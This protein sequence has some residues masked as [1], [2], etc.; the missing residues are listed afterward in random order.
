MRA[1]HR[2][3]AAP[4][5]AALAAAAAACASMG[6]PPGGPEDRKAP[7]LV[8]TAP[9]SAAVNARPDRVVFEF[10]E[11]IAERP[12]GGAGG[13]A[14]LDAAFLISPRDGEP[15]V[16]WRRERLSVRPRRGWRPNTVYTVTLLPGV[17]DLRGNARKE[18]ARV[19]F[20]TGATIPETRI[21]GVAFDW[22]AGKV[23]TRA[24]V[25][26]ISRPDST[27]YVTLSDSAGRFAFAHVPPGRYTIR[28][29]GDQ[30]NNRVLD[31]RELWDSAA[32][33]LRDTASAELYAFVHDTTGPRLQEVAVADSVTLRA[34]LDKPL[35]PTQTLT[36]ALF[37]LRAADSSVVPIVAALAPADF[38]AQQG[39]AARSRAD[40]LARADSARAAA[41]TIHKGPRLP[42]PARDSAGAA[43]DSLARD[44]PRLARP[45]PVSEV[46]LRLGRALAPA[47]AYRLR[48]VGLRNLLGIPGTSDRIITTPRPKPP[49][50]S[51]RA[52][53]A[54]VPRPVARV[55]TARA[56]PRAPAR[57]RPLG[58]LLGTI[59]VLGALLAAAVLLRN[60]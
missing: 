25:E 41:D 11:T 30:N 48:A 42:R 37:T 28:A 50:D 52:D 26:A 21:E 35:D 36:P 58:G 14:T 40:S 12:T 53:T 1:A 32:V 19:V 8:R 22:P 2:R 54:G 29:F 44:L 33:T 3:A 51:A 7:E 15:R 27:V 38:E 39:E 6:A 47:S 16:Q 34:R 9:E 17:A 49:S 13:A 46:V 10:D 43:R 59:G 5:L 24:F 57:R 55:D 4:L 56:A 20:S 45:V 23:I 31:G 60:R 18:G